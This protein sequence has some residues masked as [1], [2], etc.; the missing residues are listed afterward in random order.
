M[1]FL[2]MAVEMKGS[3]RVCEDSSGPGD[4]LDVGSEG[5]KGIKDTHGFL[6]IL[7]NLATG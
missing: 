4:T 5:N 2:R 3:G 1:A 6:W 7:A